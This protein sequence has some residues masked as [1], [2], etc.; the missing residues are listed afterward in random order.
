MT[1]A[2]RLIVTASMLA[3][4]V[5]AMAQAP[6]PTAAPSAQQSAHERLFQLFKDSDEASL[7]RNPIQALFR[8]DMR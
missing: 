2:A 8:G 4:A 3:F 1:V 7:K 5:P 6:A